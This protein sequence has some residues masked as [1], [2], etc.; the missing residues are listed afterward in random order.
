LWVK[1]SRRS[2]VKW[3]N[4][5]PVCLGDGQKTARSLGDVRKTIW[6]FICNLLLK[7]TASKAR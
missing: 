6:H 4:K 7:A 1:E 2:F 5:S 3:N